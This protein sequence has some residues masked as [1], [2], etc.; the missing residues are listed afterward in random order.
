MYPSQARM[1]YAPLSLAE[2][3][4]ENFDNWGD[5]YGLDFYPLLPFL[6]QRLMIAPEIMTVAP[7]QVLSDPIVRPFLRI[8]IK[9]S[10]LNM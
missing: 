9:F 10:L 6:Q 4:K 8:F 5:F 1:Y 7:K 2:Y 3:H